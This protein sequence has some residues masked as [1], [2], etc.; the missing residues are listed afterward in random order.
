M[1]IDF[2]KLRDKKRLFLISGPCVVEN[3]DVCMRTAEETLRICHNLNIHYI[4]KSSYV[5]A[6]RT[7]ASSFTGIGNEKALQIIQKVGNTLGIATTTDVHSVEEVELAR[8][9]VD[10]IQIPAF[11]CR[12][13]AL[14]EAAGK[15]GKII[16]IK[17]GQFMSP[18]AME[19]AVEKIQNTGNAQVL[20]T[21]R[22]NSFGYQ[23]LIVDFRSIPIMQQFAPVVI[24]CTHALQKPNAPRGVTG[25]TPQFIGTLARAAVAAGVDGLFIETHPYPDA[26]LSDGA[27]M[28]PLDELEPL[29]QTL[30]RIYNSLK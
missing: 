27:N 22:G 17:K 10:V 8:D 25:G 24:D 2:E 1:V 11:L 23:D 12:Q 9:Y 14:L 4:F 21:E 19:Y 28:L 5:K 15:T 16:N 7:S 18:A 3:E 29:L 30:V 13:T 6:N 26:A 20:L